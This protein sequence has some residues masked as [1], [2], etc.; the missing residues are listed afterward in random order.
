MS[1]KRPCDFGEIQ[2]GS[3]D[4]NPCTP[5]YDEDFRGIRIN[6]PR[7]V[8]FGP[9]TR[10]PFIGGFAKIIVAGVCQLEYQTLGLR[11]EWNN[12]IVLV[13]TDTRTRR[14]YSGTM[15]PFGSPAPPTDPLAKGGLTPEDFAG[16]VIGSCFNP[17]LARELGLPER[18]AE[19][20]V[21]ATLGPYKSNVVHIKL[22][23]KK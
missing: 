3:G 14:V 5:E 11:G 10:D 15:K 16:A 9:D 6:A 19:Y 7:E 1:E 4:E 20:D 2:S 22:S 13:A 12:A 8:Y 23:R 21:H 17:N 18:E